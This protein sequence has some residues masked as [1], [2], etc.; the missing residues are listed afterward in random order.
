MGCQIGAQ[1]Q[2]RQAGTGL[3]WYLEDRM[4]AVHFDPGVFGPGVAQQSSGT[5]V[6]SE[7]IT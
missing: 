4:D 5:G 3:S 2:V 6:C 7:I 1:N